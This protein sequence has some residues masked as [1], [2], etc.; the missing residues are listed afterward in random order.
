[1][2]T[3]K[4]ATTND[5]AATP[6]RKGIFATVKAV[7]EV[8]G[9]PELQNLK[10]ATGENEV[11]FISDALHVRKHWTRLSDV[12]G[13]DVKKAVLCAKQIDDLAAYAEAGAKGKDALKAYLDTLPGCPFCDKAEKFPGFYT[14]EEAYAFNV[15][16][17]GTVY[18]WEIS[19]PTIQNQLADFEEN[20]RWAKYMP[21]GR[22]SDMV[23]IVTKESTGP[24]PINV[25]YTVSGDPGSEPLSDEQMKNYVEKAVDLTKIKRPKPIDTEDGATWWAELLA[26]CPDPK[27]GEKPKK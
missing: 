3:K 17:N 18:V 13:K 16:S 1:M 24:L 25:K 4:P 6:A 21:N 20:P 10:L 19:Q 9:G 2:T 11:R 8:T 7:N 14:L 23:V 22:L 12:H 5:V 15:V 27:D 26:K